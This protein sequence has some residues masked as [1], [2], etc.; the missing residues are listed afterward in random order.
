MLILTLRLFG[1]LEPAALFGRVCMIDDAFRQQTGC[2]M[3]RKGDDRA[4]SHLTR[5]APH[6][7][8]RRPRQ[9]RTQCIDDVA[10]YRC[11][12]L[13]GASRLE[14]FHAVNRLPAYRTH[15]QPFTERIVDQ[16]CTSANVE[17]DECCVRVTQ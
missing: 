7:P 3:D 16:R 6:A 17:R 13:A 10:P 8:L 5:L 9:S 2:R 15:P 14:V 11:D 12:V 4:V 1:M